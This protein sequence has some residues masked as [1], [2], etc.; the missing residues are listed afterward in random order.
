LP[1]TTG[2]TALAAGLA[3]A[4]CSVLAWVYLL[5]QPVGIDSIFAALAGMAGALMALCAGAIA[6][7][8]YFMRYR[9]DG[10]QLTVSCLWMQEAVPLGQ[11][12]GVYSGRRLG[13]K[14]RV[15]GLSLPGLYIGTSS[16]AELGKPKFYGTTT[17]PSAVVVVTAAQRAYAITPVDLKGFREQLVT[18][19]EALSRDEVAHAPEPAAEGSLIPSIP[20]LR[21]RICLVLASA[22]LV[23]VFASFAYVGI[24]LAGLPPSIPLH[25]D[26]AGQPDMIVP[27]ADALRIPIIGMVILGVN[28]LAAAA[29][30]A[31]Q[32]DAGRVLAGATLFVELI[33][34][35]AILR[36]VH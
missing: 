21:D 17:D 9:I 28:W 36:V 29:L 35:M 11:I 1:S 13:R 22:A 32:R 34:F 14:A 27:R 3:L 7:G 26:A 4:L 8:Y 25:F 23:V 19:L 5:A 31:W 20:L 16:G 10:G 2:R 18:R 15:E 30:H 12:D 6:A 33:A 24:K